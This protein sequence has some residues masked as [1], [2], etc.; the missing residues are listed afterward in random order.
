MVTIRSY[1]ELRTF[2]SYDVQSILL[3]NRQNTF[4]LQI[5]LSTIIETL[6]YRAVDSALQ[7]YFGLDCRYGRTARFNWSYRSNRYQRTVWSTGS[8]W[9]GRVYGCNGRHRRTR[10]NWLRRASRTERSD[11]LSVIQASIST[12]SKMC[13][14]SFRYS[15]M[16]FLTMFWQRKHIAAFAYLHVS[17]QNSFCRCIMN[18]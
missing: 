18:F 2:N 10:W 5:G 17:L 12:V 9:P 8:N 15:S 7:I 16:T 3:G 1:R 13:R 14:F 6:L 11:H 4:I